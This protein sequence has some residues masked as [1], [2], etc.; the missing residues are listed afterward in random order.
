M[1]KEVK[2]NP[3]TS[4]YLRKCTNKK[5]TWIFYASFSFWDLENYRPKYDLGNNGTLDEKGRI[6][7]KEG[8]F[9]TSNPKYF[10]AGDA[11]NGGAEVVNAAGE[12][13]VAARDIHEYLN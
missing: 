11:V 5:R 6:K 9:Q 1:Q 2:K 10:A 3:F 4:S 12:A 8:S 13:K 7:V